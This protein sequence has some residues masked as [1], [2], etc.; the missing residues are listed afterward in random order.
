[1]ETSFYEGVE[2]R[3]LAHTPADVA[4][5]I[6]ARKIEELSSDIKLLNQDVESLRDEINRLNKKERQCTV[7][8]DGIYIRNDIGTVRINYIPNEDEDEED[9]LYD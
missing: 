4:I 9:D 7:E 5:K 8:S 2:E 3:A 1:M 6:M